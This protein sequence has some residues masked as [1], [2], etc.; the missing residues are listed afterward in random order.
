MNTR[1]F[2]A[3]A[4]CL[5]ASGFGVVAASQPAVG[6][7]AGFTDTAVFA[8]LTQP[9]VVRFAP[10]GEV[11]VAEKSGL[12]KRFDDLS[13]T[14]PTVVA[15]LRADVYNFW[16][17]GL[18]G[19]ALSPGYA[20]DGTI[21][22]LYTRDALPGGSSPHWQTGDP[23]TSGDPCP[24]TPGATADGC[25]ATG[26]LLRLD[27]GT[28]TLPKTAADGTP[29]I[30]DWCQQ[31]PSHSIGSL[32]FGADGFLYASGG[33]GANFNVADYG[34]Y[35][36]PLNPCGD[37]PGPPG[38][39][40][41]PPSAEGGALRSQDVRTNGDPLGL[42]GTVIRIDPV[43][44]AGAPGNPLAGSADANARR[45]VA[46]GMRNPFRIA[47]RPG[48]SDLYVGDVGWGTWEEINRIPSPADD[49]VDNL[50]WPCYE[51]SPRQSG[52][53]NLDLA[54]CENLY[55][56]GAGAVTAPTLAYQ[57]TDQVA[58][59]DGCPTGSSSISGLAFYQGGSYPAQ[60]DGALF[61]TDYTRRCL[62]SM[63]PNAQ[64]VPDPST[65]AF[66]SAL[67]GGA[68]NLEIGPAGDLF[69]ADFDNGTI[70]RIAY[71]MANQPPTAQL[72]ANPTSGNEPLTV[73]FS[74]SGSSDPE[75]D[76]LTG[77][78]DLD[79]DGAFD[80]ATGLTASRTFTTTGPKR[81]T[82][83]VT[84]PGGLTSTASTVVEVG[85]APVATITSPTATTSWKVGDSIAVSGSATDGGTPLPGTAL[86]WDVDIH[87]CSAPDVCHVHPITSFTGQTGTIDAPDHDYPSYITVRLTATDSSGLTDVKTVRIDPRTVNLTF[88][89]N[90]PGLVVSV[91]GSTQTAPFAKEAIVGATYSISTAASQQLGAT[92]YAFAGWS[93]GGAHSH[94]ITVPASDTTYTASFT[95]V[96]SSSLVGAWGFEEGAGDT[97][98]DASG[99]GNNGTISGASWTTAGKYGRA[100]SFD[101]VND[102]VTVADSAS[103]DLTDA[104]TLEAW[105]RPTSAGD[106]WHSVLMKETPSS[107]A[108]GLYSGG[109]PNHPS[110][111]V[112]INGA[113][114]VVEGTGALPVDAWTHLATTYDGTTLRLYVNGTEA[115]SR[116]AS[117]AAPVSGRRCGSAATRSGASGSPVRST[118]SASTT[119][120]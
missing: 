12:V 95:Q 71:S 21:Y 20:T 54:V 119:G 50:G 89:T 112:T 14:T 26:R 107:L 42:D 111:W 92:S 5:V 80:D 51:G 16:D 29:L 113:D 28:G 94:T 115:A 8:G 117:G 78:W 38:T 31:Y 37:P 100:L 22:A 85:V 61:F 13:D 18:L 104:Y 99:T 34:Q 3:A 48:T 67:P 62:W 17:R 56:E 57:H 19:L 64:G 15:D 66:F 47:F 65:L 75:G 68:V 35:G 7:P 23:L 10:N 109:I 72:T 70:R 58:L 106:G 53:D 44:G 77:A 52:F 84:D 45:V 102:L 39:V 82:V 101:G 55:L 63:R 41:T 88:A 74:A 97:T 4:L 114:V 43:T 27:I 25:V 32:Q 69:Y 110:S 49:A 9:T 91:G 1:M 105:V 108:Y 98:A 40:L 11:L 81:V 93:D 118:T 79:D 120:C 86:T 2:P 46:H 116:V 36:S 33:D 59:G 6:V 83:M 60:Y 87:H 24:A 90:P 73:A 76:P 96:A 103:L 30:T